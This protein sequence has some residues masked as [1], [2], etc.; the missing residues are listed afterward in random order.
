MNSSRSHLRPDTGKIEHRTVASIDAARHPKIGQG[1]EIRPPHQGRDHSLVGDDE[2]KRV[3]RQ[4]R[5]NGRAVPQHE[6][7]IEAKALACVIEQLPETVEP[8]FGLCHKGPRVVVRRC[9]PS[10]DRSATRRQYC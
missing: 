7:D 9:R 3:R 8:L 6:A 10:P 4:I 2:R 1:L 5:R